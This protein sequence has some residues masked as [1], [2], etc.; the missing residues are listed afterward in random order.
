MFSGRGVGIKVVVACKTL[1]SLAITGW[2]GVGVGPNVF[3]FLELA[4][5]GLGLCRSPGGM[6]VN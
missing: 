5:L 1:Y 6:L 3:G 2:K 4:M